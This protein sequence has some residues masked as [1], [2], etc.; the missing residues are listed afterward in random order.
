M[1]SNLVV[2]EDAKRVANDVFNLT[3]YPWG[4]IW[5]YLTVKSPMSRVFGHG[6]VTRAC[7]KSVWN[8]EH[9]VH[10]EDVQTDDEY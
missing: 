5:F 3:G 6:D 9:W 2:S 7:K 10:Q 1:V 8:P 4:W